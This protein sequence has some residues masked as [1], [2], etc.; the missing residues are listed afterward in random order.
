MQINKDK[1][2]VETYE[3]QTGVLSKIFVSEVPDKRV[4][5]LKNNTLLVMDLRDS[6]DAKIDASSQV[7]IAGKR[8]TPNFP[9]DIDEKSYRPYYQIDLDSQYNAENQS[10]LLIEVEQGQYDFIENMTIEFWLESDT[11]IDWSN[12]VLEFEVEEKPYK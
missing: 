12:S 1:D 4:H 8:P 3:N 6:G 10:Q 9:T 2:Y 5:T 7:V 11:Q